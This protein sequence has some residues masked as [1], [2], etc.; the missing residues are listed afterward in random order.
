MVE[1]LYVRGWEKRNRTNFY[2]VMLLVLVSGIQNQSFGT[3]YHMNTWYGSKSVQ[4]S[5]HFGTEWC[6]K[7]W[8]SSEFFLSY[9]LRYFSPRYILENI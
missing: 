2:W 3:F 5:T 8:Y 9:C 1:F 6:M 4:I 7:T